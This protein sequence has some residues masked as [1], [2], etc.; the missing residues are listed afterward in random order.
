MMSLRS[1]FLF[2]LV[3]NLPH[4]A[5]PF[6]KP[7]FP[8][9]MHPSTSIPILPSKVPQRYICKGPSLPFSYSISDSPVSQPTYSPCLALSAVSQSSRGLKYSLRA[10]PSISPVP[11]VISLRA[12]FHSTDEP[13][14][15]IDLRRTNKAQYSR[16]SKKNILF[17]W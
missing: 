2:S 1:S 4:F 7:P 13:S 3:P 17:L 14:F 5:C 15:I 8:D 10:V 6:P 16:T 12:F 9:H 11:P